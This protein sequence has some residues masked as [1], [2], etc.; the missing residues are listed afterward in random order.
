MPDWSYHTFFKPALF[1]LTPRKARSLTLQ[2]MNRLVTLPFGHH[3]IEFFGHMAP[4][5]AISAHICGV[6]TASPIGVSGQVDPKLEGTRALSK[7]GF[8]YLEVGPIS[9][10]PATK[11]EIVLHKKGEEIGYSHLHENLG[12]ENTIDALSRS[13]P[14]IPVLIKISDESTGKIV[15]LI[16]KLE[17]FA[18]WFVVDSTI[19]LPAIREATSTPIFVGVS[20][21]KQLDEVEI[22]DFDGIYLPEGVHNRIGQFELETKIEM[23]KTVQPSGK[24]IIASGGVHQPSDALDLID[25]GADLVNIHS[26]FIFYGPGLPKRI[27]EAIAYRYQES[28]LNQKGWFASFLMGFGVLLAGFIASFV[29]LTDVLLAPDERFLGMS[30]EEIQEFSE[31]LFKFM[32]HDRISLAGVMISAGF[33][34]MMLAYFGIRVGQHWARK[35]FYIAATLGFLNF[36]Y[37]IGF[38]YLDPIHLLYNALILPFFIYGFIQTRN[39]PHGSH[40]Q[41]LHNSRAWRKSQFGQTMFI[42]LGGAFLTAGMVISFIGV[43]DVFV[44]EDL[45]FLQLEPNEIHEHNHQFISLIAHDRAGFGGALISAGILIM[46]IAMWGFREGEKW[47]WWTLTVGGIPGFAAGIG[48]HY[49]IGYVDQYHLAPAYFAILLYLLGVIYSYSYLMTAKRSPE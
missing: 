14:D 45:G 37:F 5:K 29:G 10:E 2:T 28:P 12:V 4:S 19:D 17:P 41:N 16:K 22:E 49:H 39:M 48:I 21:Q 35:V 9:L 23:I 8:G 1:K 3:I 13:A 30:K 6:E 31:H 15:T 47:I 11:Q 34:Y 26:G 38:G 7:L 46:L 25:A 36:F 42:I 18:D 27:N 43:T 32:S 33:L 24:P 20:D 40:G 44:K